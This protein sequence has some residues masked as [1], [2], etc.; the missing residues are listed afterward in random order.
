MAI[1]YIEKYKNVFTYLKQ[2]N[3]ENKYIYQIKRLLKDLDIDREIK[4]LLWY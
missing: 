1:K 3:D 2:F 4:K